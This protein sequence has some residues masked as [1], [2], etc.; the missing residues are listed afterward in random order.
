M[1]KID[2][3]AHVFTPHLNLA[4]ERRYAPSYDALIETF[5]KNFE[6]K[7][8]DAGMLIQPSFLGTDNSYMIEAINA[9]PDKL[10]GVAVVE[11]DVSLSELQ[12]LAKNNIVGI[13][14]NLYGKTI[15]DLTSDL[16]QSCLALIKQLDWHV[17]LHID[18]VTLPSLIDVLLK[19]GIKVVVD[20]FG[21]PTA[22]AP[23]EDKGVKY[24]L[25]IAHTKQVWVKISGVYRLDKEAGLAVSVQKARV[26]LSKYLGAFGPERLLWGSDW[27]HTQFEDTVSYDWVW[28]T[29]LQ[30]VPDEQTRNIILTQSFAALL[31][32]Y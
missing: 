4:K 10:Y 24:L 5:I 1:K 2:T 28:D 32:K 14:L 17:E 20:H 18:A 31:P 29:F 16:W 27:P 26:L 11:P 25:S 7:G 19:A 9:H 21:K 3:H 13:R 22:T 12:M 6:S 8:L 30:L 23:L 15:P